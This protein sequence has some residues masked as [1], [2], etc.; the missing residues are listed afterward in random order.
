[1]YKCA[2]LCDACYLRGRPSTF[3]VTINI[4]R[5][6]Q[7]TNC[8]KKHFHPL[9]RIHATT[10][11]FGT[12][13]WDNFKSPIRRLTSQVSDTS[14]VAFGNYPR[15]DVDTF[16][17][18]LHQTMRFV[19]IAVNFQWFDKLLVSTKKISVNISPIYPSK[20]TEFPNGTQCL[21]KRILNRVRSTA[22]SYN[23]QYPLLSLNSTS[24][25][26]RLLPWLPVTSFLFF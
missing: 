11:R 25:C 18:Y 8:L 24:S 15:F 17:L 7:S 1:M 10:G 21:P 2:C 23:F 26:S 9:K 5:K 14:E 12:G 16:Q 4:N 19:Y 20:C 3:K 22:S 13:S 6:Q